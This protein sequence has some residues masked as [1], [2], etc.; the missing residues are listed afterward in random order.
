MI[1]TMTRPY[2][3]IVDADFVNAV[4][5]EFGDSFV[6]G[7]NPQLVLVDY[8]SNQ[9]YSAAHEYDVYFYKKPDGLYEIVF[10]ATKGKKLIAFLS[11]AL[12]VKPD[13]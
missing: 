5:R 11:K 12:N 4:S 3:G 10:P 6:G 9:G 8:F 13:A 2:S 1:W 7:A